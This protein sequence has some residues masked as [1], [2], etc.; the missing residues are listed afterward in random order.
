M[1]LLGRPYN[2]EWYDLQ[3]NRSGITEEEEYRNGIP[4]EVAI[5]EVKDLLRDAIVVGHDIKHDFRAL[6]LPMY[7]TA[8]RVFDTA[9]NASLNALVP[10]ERGKQL[11]KPAGLAHTLLGE[12]TM[13]QFMT[14][15]KMRLLP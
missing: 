12:E 2:K 14:R 11:S 6:D 1:K 4:Y 3:T 10:S 13:L 7:P 15:L 9:T 5:L 8:H